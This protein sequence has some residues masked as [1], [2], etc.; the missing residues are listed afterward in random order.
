[1]CEFADLEHNQH[2]AMLRQKIGAAR[3]ISTTLFT[4]RHAG[5]SRL[6]VEESY[7]FAMLPL[8]ILHDEAKSWIKAIDRQ[9]LPVTAAIWIS[10]HKRE[11][12]L[13][14]GLQPENRV[15]E[16]EHVT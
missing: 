5:N 2:I 14:D 3:I 12:M 15:A 4:P 9:W 6:I 11:A 16:I 13:S 7:T 8:I 10:G 1:M